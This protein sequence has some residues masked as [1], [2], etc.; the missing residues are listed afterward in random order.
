M[1]ATVGA[2]YDGFRGCF[3][4]GR[5]KF[6]R[7]AF[8]CQL[9]ELELDADWPTK[10]SWTHAPGTTVQ[11]IKQPAGSV[12]RVVRAPLSI[13]DLF[14][15][16]S[17]ITGPSCCEVHGATIQRQLHNILRRNRPAT[18]PDTDSIAAAAPARQNDGHGREGSE[19]LGRGHARSEYSF[20]T[21]Q[22]G[23]AGVYTPPLTF[24]PHEWQ[25]ISKFRTHRLDYRLSQ[26]YEQW[27]PKH[28]PSATSQDLLTNRGNPVRA[29]SSEHT[30]SPYI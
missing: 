3:R 4:S 26:P 17:N 13:R 2:G 15:H 29:S 22:S 18:A 10:I 30:K 20:A 19:E 23:I 12:P 25:L 16:D 1:A 24:S 14:F 28:R 21:M 5:S 7:L 11:G 9:T 8:G 27:P 6:W